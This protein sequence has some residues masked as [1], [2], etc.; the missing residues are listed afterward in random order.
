MAELDA[1]TLSEYDIEY[2]DF[3]MTTVAFRT[4]TGHPDTNLGA[5]GLLFIFVVIFLIIAACCACMGVLV[6]FGC[7]KSFL[8][9]RCRRRGDE[10]IGREP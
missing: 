3:N 6:L 8:C 4:T 2:I 7:M 5:W 10:F 9:F 1:T